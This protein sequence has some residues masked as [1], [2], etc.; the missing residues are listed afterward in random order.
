MICFPRVLPI[1][2]LGSRKAPGGPPEAKTM[3]YMREY[4][5][6]NQVTNCVQSLPNLENACIRMPWDVLEQKRADHT[7]TPEVR[8]S[9]GP[10]SL[11][12]G[13]SIIIRHSPQ[14][15]IGD[16]PTA[17]SLYVVSMLYAHNICCLLYT[18]DAA[19][20]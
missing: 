18:S 8:S 7:Y 19:D 13:Q 3:R 5:P 4:A 20:E 12:P 9:S 15:V 6:E 1:R 10:A 17:Q 14:S 16:V 11:H 2:P